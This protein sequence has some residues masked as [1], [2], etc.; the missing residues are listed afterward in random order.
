MPD[1]QNEHG[2]DD[3]TEELYPLTRERLYELAWSEPMLSIAKKYEVSSSYLARVCTRMNVPRPA[4]G[5]WTKVACGKAVTKPPLLEARPEDELEWDRENDSTPPQRAK[6]RAPTRRPRKASRKPERPGTHRMV[7]G[8]KAHFLKTRTP[9]NGYLRPY[10][11]ILVDLI[12]SEKGLD[13]ALTLVNQLFWAFEDYGYRVA[14]SPPEEHTSRPQVDEREKPKK[15]RRDPY[16]NRHWGP[17]RSTVVYVGDIGFGV[18][19]IELS[20]S[21]EVKYRDGEW[22]PVTELKP[23]QESRYEYYSTSHHEDLPSGKFCLQVYS[24]YRGTGWVRRWELP[25]GKDATRIGHKI[26]R[27]LHNACPEILALIEAERLRREQAEKE[28]EEWKYNHEQE[29]LEKFWKKANSASLDQLDKII[30]DWSEARRLETFFSELE[31]SAKN[32]APQE[33]E[34]VSQ[35]IDEILGYVGRP[36]AISALKSWRSP[37][38]I[39]ASIG[40]PLPD[41]AQADEEPA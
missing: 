3:K 26:A 34:E 17:H 37:T 39:M 40:E 10:K 36:D 15:D 32:L 22:V 4:P 20:K 21:V 30:A 24:A 29:R 18:T 12:V 31:N 5:Y 19:L 7:A 33:R 14:F 27:E 23:R 8:A 28:Y 25:K 41:S 2:E 11:K 9:R 35:R 16:Y 38:E 6:P 13:Q 1:D